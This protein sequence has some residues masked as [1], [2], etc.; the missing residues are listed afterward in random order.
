M[1]AAIAHETA[2]ARADLTER[3]RRLPGATVHPGAANFVLVHLPQGGAAAR[4]LRE[5]GIAVRPC[6]SFPGLTADHLRLTVRDPQPT[7]A[8]RP[9]SRGA[10]SPSRSAARSPRCGSR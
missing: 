8:S 6:A 9:R 7:P 3:L 4:R 10:L 2:R 1:R 5:Q